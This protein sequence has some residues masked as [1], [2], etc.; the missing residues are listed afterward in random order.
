MKLGK[1]SA[2][3][4]LAAIL[5]M[6][7]PAMA[8]TSVPGD[9]VR[10]QINGVNVYSPLNH[11]WKSTSYVDVAAYA[12]LTNLDY[13]FDAKNSTVKINDI[14]LHVRIYGGTPTT[15]IRPLAE[16]AGAELVSW[17]GTTKSVYVLDLPEG[18]V[19][20]ASTA[21]GVTERWASPKDMLAGPVYGIKDGKLVFLEYV[22]DQA[23]FV[24]GKNI[25]EIP[26]MKGLP[27][28]AVD[29]TDIELKSSDYI[30]HHYFITHKAHLASDTAAVQGEAGTMETAKLPL[31]SLGDSI[32]FGF[33]LEET[34]EVPSPAAFPYLIGGGTTYETTNLA[35][36]GWDSAELLVGL[37]TAEF[38][39]ALQQANIVTLNIGSNDLFG[40][41]KAIIAKYEADNS[42]QPTEAD[43]ALLQAGLTM[44]EDNFPII[45]SEIRKHTDAPIVIYTLY[46]PFPEMLAP[47]LYGLAES[48]LLASNDIIKLTAAANSNTVIADAYTKFEGKQISYVMIRQYDIHPTRTGQRAL[49]ALADEAIL[50]L[51]KD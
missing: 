51:S 39:E 29:H 22:I 43:K 27:L 28:P 46:N 17:D 35:V 8:Q 38:Q 5:C 24:N 42:Y 44:F 18:T 19:P 9:D 40:P 12:K 45:V 16:A 49:A 21:S 25:I 37:Q 15:P 50:S 48:Y 3:A 6:S 4:I 1:L 10:V 13:E 7:V 34:D 32:P 47:M 11:L 14:I 26:G 36:S 20:E 31:V 41:G 2:V 33:N 30:I 23:I